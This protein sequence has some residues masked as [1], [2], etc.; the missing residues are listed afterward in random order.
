MVGSGQNPR[1]DSDSD[2]RALGAASLRGSRPAAP[3][4]DAERVVPLA[5]GDHAGRCWTGRRLNWARGHLQGGGTRGGTAT[6]ASKQA[7]FSY[8]IC[9]M[10]WT[11]FLQSHGPWALWCRPRERPYLAFLG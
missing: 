10:A 11:Q 9:T 2:Y 3:P 1:K 5:R 4:A 6:E 8:V 7:G